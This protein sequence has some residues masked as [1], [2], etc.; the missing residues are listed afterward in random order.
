MRP[1]K[2]QLGT[3]PRTINL[4][5]PTREFFDFS[6]QKDFPLRFLGGEGKRRVQLRIDLLNAFN[7]PV[8]QYNNLGNT[9]FGLGTFP[10]E[11]TTEQVGGIT[12]PITLAEYNTWRL[13][14]GSRQLLPGEP[15]QVMRYTIRFAH[16]STPFDCQPVPELRRA[17]HCRTISSISNCRRDLPLLIHW[18]LIFGH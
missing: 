14:T 10:T 18:H 3:A 7:H 8:F 9:P 16:K 1:V 5:A 2:G 13:L 6:L 11:I 12:Q 4:H 15:A 17:A